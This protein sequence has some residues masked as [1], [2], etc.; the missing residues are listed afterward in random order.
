M[1]SIFGSIAECRDLALVTHAHSQLALP[2][3]NGAPLECADTKSSLSHGA[4]QISLAS[5]RLFASNVTVGLPPIS[6]VK[7]K[8]KA[9]CHVPFAFS[10]ASRANRD[11]FRRSRFS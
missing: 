2:S 11:A 3:H 9:S 6:I 1:A 5:R 10:A 8:E 4:L 7:T